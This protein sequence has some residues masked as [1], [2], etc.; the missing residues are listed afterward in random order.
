MYI[1][2]HFRVEDE[3][4]LYDF[5]DQN[6]FGIL[7]SN[8][9]GVPF[10][11]H[12]PLILDREKGCLYG[13]FARGNMQWKDIEGQEV[14]AIFQGPHSY[15]SS[16]W[17]ETNLSVPTWNYVTVHVYGQLEMMEDSAQLLGTLDEMVS[18]YEKPESPYQ[19]D[20]SNHELVESMM[21]G[22]VG[23][24]L[25]ITKLEGKWKLSQNHPVERQQRV[26][27]ELEKS[28]LEDDRE[29]AKLMKNNIEGLA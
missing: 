13:H 2:K 1:P 21:K 15:I 23:F 8:Y 25:K 11:T 24:T 16:S 22:I 28:V 9:D 27:K 20:E 18:K 14:L 12:L 29:I 5:M 7:I 6:S 3:A 19:L 10:A 26:I 4:V 17:Y